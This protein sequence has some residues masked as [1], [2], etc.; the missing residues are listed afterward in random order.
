MLR[1]W[2]VALQG[3]LSPQ[4]GRF[5]TTAGALRSEYDSE[6]RGVIPLRI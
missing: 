3:Y 6:L 5:L 4:S 2:L 1:S